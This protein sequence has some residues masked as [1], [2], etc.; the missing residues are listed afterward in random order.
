MDRKLQAL[1]DLDLTRVNHIE[2]TLFEHLEGTKNLL[3]RWGASTELQDAGL[4]HA[5]YGTNGFDLPL[6]SLDKRAQVSAII[7]EEAEVI[8]YLY[9][10]CE[11]DIFLP[12]I[13]E[14][15]LLKF[16]NRFTGQSHIISNKMLRNF[17][18]LT[19]ANEV[20]IAGKNSSFLQNNAE[21]L[22]RLASRMQPWL[23]QAAKA[24]A[25]DIFGYHS[26]SYKNCTIQ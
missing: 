16:P 8:V 7:G 2:G 1:V 20:E 10:A 14:D 9:C 22:F 19:L 11:R 13:G 4:Y 18:E 12:S 17:C 21:G 15:T 23:S 25:A 5:I 24:C 6:L 26:I 3:S